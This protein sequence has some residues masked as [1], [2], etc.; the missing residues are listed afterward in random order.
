MHTPTFTSTI[1]ALTIFFANTHAT[2][3]SGS[4]PA[5]EDS[6]SPSLYDGSSSSSASASA[7][8]PALHARKACGEDTACVKYYSNSGCLASGEL[9]SFIPDCTGHVSLPFASGFFL[10]SLSSV[11]LSP[12]PTLFII[13]T[14]PSLNLPHLFA[15]LP[16]T[17]PNLLPLQT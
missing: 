9:G 14:L 1:L 3:L 13:L 4:S 7:S 2:P 10:V 8:N 17:Q 6:L 12:S 5:L 11:S 15:P 16:R